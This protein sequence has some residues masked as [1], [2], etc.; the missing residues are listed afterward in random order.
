MRRPAEPSGISTRTTSAPAALPA[1]RSLSVDS[2]PGPDVTELE[3]SLVAF[4][5]DPAGDVTVDQTY[6]DATKAM[7]ERWQRGLGVEH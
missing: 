6:D 4:G 1:W 2:E 3:L 7:V 5:Y